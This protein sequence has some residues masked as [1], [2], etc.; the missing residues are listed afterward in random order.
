MG[1]GA[2]ADNSQMTWAGR[3]GEAKGHLLCRL[4]E[5]PGVRQAAV[6]LWQFLQHVHELGEGRSLFLFKGPAEEK[7]VLKET[8]MW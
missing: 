5:V 2:K 3:R 1:R 8:S 7:N 4:P 6:S